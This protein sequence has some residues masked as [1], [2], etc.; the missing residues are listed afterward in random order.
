[1]TRPYES[2]FIRRFRFSSFLCI[3]PLPVPLSFFF[4][5]LAASFPSVGAS[6]SSFVGGGPPF[7]G[8]G[9]PFVFLLLPFVF[10]VLLWGKNSLFRLL[11]ICALHCC[12]VCVVRASIHGDF[13]LKSYTDYQSIW[14]IRIVNPYDYMDWWSVWVIWI[15]NSYVSNFFLCTC[16]FLATNYHLTLPYPRQQHTY[17]TRDKKTLR[18]GG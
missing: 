7:V 5:L 12:S 10:F 13:M 17:T 8:G 2:L 4:F 6:S 11:L 1:M 16:S 9:S 14:P 15:N 3:L 18:K